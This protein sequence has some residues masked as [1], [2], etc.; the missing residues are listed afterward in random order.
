MKLLVTLKASSK[1]FLGIT[2][3][4]V[5]FFL[6]MSFARVDITTQAIGFVVPYGDST[7]VGSLIA[8]QIVEVNVREGDTVEKGD[9]LIKLTP[10]VTNANKNEIETKL[11]IVTKQLQ[12]K[13]SLVGTTVSELDYLELEK[14]EA[15]LKGSLKRI[16]FELLH[17]DIVSPIDGVIQKLEYKNVGSV[18][19]QFA[20]VVTIIPNSKKLLIEGRLLVKDRGYVSIGQSAKIK[21][22]NQ[23]QL[24]FNSIDAKI[25][26]ISPDAVQS[27]TAAWYDIELEIDVT[28][29]TSGDLTYQL[30]PG[31]HVLVFILTGERTI[32]SY[33]TTPFHNSIGEALQ[34]R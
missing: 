21:L 12:I 30:V 32:L 4:F 14:E 22:A 15:E 1:F 28:E 26:S 2:S 9:I 8:G 19:E 34:E 23:D 20:K 16:N 10:T 3:L 24:K 6:W 5:I 29:F 27:D 17:A 13:K 25:I 31:I 18:V 7:N 11:N 33:I